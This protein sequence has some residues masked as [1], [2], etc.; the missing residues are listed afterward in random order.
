[1]T[2]KKSSSD[3][4]SLPMGLGMA[5]AQDARALEYFTGLNPEE[6]EKVIDQTHQIQSKEQMRAFV[7]QLGQQGLS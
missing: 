6:K 2:K 5:L 3:S 7:H 1:M 4:F